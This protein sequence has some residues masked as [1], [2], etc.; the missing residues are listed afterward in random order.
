M[1]LEI[2]IIETWQLQISTS[3]WIHW[4]RCWFTWPLILGSRCNLAF[5]TRVLLA[6]LCLVAN[7]IWLQEK[8]LLYHAVK[9]VWK[10]PRSTSILSVPVYTSFCLAQCVYF[11]VTES[12]VFLIWCLYESSKAYCGHY[13]GA[14]LWDFRSEMV[15]QF[16]RSSNT[17]VKLTYQDQHTLT[18]LN[19]ALLLNLLQ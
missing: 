7:I 4:S 15:G 11:C 13:Y 14:M 16:C 5:P 18:W 6:E 3:K 10:G 12:V 1:G 2:G 17:C 8:W 9:V 19:T